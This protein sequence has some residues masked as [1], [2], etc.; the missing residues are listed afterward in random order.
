MPREQRLTEILEDI[1]KK[2]DV[3]FEPLDVDGTRYEV[4]T[5][6]NMA[7]RL[8]QLAVA[9]AI[10][11]PLRDLPL[12]AKVWPGSLVL[13]RFLRKFEPE[14][15]SLLELGCGMGALSLVAARYGFRS[16]TATDVDR[17]AL[18]F[19]MAHVLK[20]GLENR[21]SVQFLD[22]TAP[23]E[24]LPTF[25]FIAASELLYLDDLHRPL[26]KF[27]ERGLVSGGRAFFCT[28]IA[29]LKPRFQKLAEKYLS[30]F[31]IQEGK[32]GLKCA[33]PNG[34]EERRIFS[35]IILEKP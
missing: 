17:D 6:H 12:W 25:D 18:N 4:L 10:E 15:K 14:G 5:I 28:D 34:N 20:N 13:G 3:D 22:V 16:I 2:W 30:R 9:H 24:K 33:D 35:I 29:R 8:D 7:A 1:R 19:T 21:I 26:L 31:H 32:I 27:L 11:Q 23:P